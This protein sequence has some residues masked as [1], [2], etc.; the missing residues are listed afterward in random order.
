MELVTISHVVNKYVFALDAYDKDGIS[1]AYLKEIGK[2][3]SYEERWNFEN[4][5][6]HI[7]SE[8][9]KVIIGVKWLGTSDIPTFDNGLQE[10]IRW[11][12]HIT[13]L[14]SHIYSTVILQNIL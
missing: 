11:Y 12:K 8:S 13:N 14:I 9:R 10:L 5:L 3:P 2:G 6:Q 1:K 4:K 7:A